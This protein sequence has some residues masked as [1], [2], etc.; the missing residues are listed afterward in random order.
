MDDAM[1]QVLRRRSAGKEGMARASAA[2]LLDRDAA[3]AAH[4]LAAEELQMRGDL[5]RAYPI[6]P[7][8]FGYSACGFADLAACRVLCT[9]PAERTLEDLHGAFDPAVAGT[10]W[11][12]CGPRQLDPALAL[13]AFLLDDE[14]LAARH[15]VR[16]RPESMMD[17]FLVRSLSLLVRGR[18]AELPAVFAHF[19]PLYEQAMTHGL[20][21]SDS[22]AFLHIRLLAAL[23]RARERDLVDL[24]TLPDNIPYA[25]V[26][27]VAALVRGN[28]KALLP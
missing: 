28:G 16:C 3:S 18:T 12:D 10:R 22:H 26:W 2:L 6:T 5:A 1:R 23:Q 13:I 19:A 25:P 27:F 24:S 7:G 21:R 8:R 9:Q 17:G 4:N 14:P 20:W 11:K 15:L